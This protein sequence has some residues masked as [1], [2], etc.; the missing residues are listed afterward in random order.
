MPRFET[1][2]CLANRSANNGYEWSALQTFKSFNDF[3]HETVFKAGWCQTK[4]QALIVD[5]S[6]P[7]LPS[8]CLALR[9]LWSAINYYKIIY[10][11]IN[12]IIK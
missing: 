7:S 1:V 6:D 3:Q 10:H 8:W 11:T 2:W 12:N 5:V 9:H 4:I